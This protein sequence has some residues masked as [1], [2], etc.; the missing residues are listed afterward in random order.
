VEVLD[1]AS[2]SVLSGTRNVQ[3]IICKEVRGAK[4]TG[5]KGIY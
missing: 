4:R 3:T 2:R 5:I 1:Q